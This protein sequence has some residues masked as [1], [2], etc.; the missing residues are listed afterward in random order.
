MGMKVFASAR[1]FVAVTPSDST[2][3]TCKALY[4]GGAGTLA[5]SAGLTGASISFVGLTAGMMLPVELFQGR[6]MATG[7]TCTNIV[8]LNW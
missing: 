3:I 8:A 1:N 2:L 5:L 4:I 6:V 7:T